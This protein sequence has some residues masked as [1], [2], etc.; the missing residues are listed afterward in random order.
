MDNE[1]KEQVDQTDNQLDAALDTTRSHEDEDDEGESGRDDNDAESENDNDEEDEKEIITDDD[2]R[3]PG[4]EVRKPDI[5]D[6]QYF[7][8]LEE[9]EFME[10]ENNIFSPEAK[11]QLHETDEAPMLAQLIMNMMKSHAPESG[12]FTQQCNY[13]QGVKKCGTKAETAAL[14]E[15]KQQHARKCFH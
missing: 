8:K 9:I 1:T 15:I 11:E 13:K 3:Y 6:G 10:S 7:E 12:T 5:H 4:K 14:K 2:R